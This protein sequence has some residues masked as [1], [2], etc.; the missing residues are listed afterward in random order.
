MDIIY[1]AVSPSGWGA[2]VDYDTKTWTPWNPDKWVL[3]WGGTPVSTAAAAGDPVAEAAQLRS[4]EAYH[5]SPSVP[6]G[7]WLGLA[8]NWAI[9]NSGTLYRVRG[10]NRSGATSGDY[11]DDGIPENHE[12]VAVVFIVGTGQDVSAKAFDTFRNFYAS[13]PQLTLV[14]GHKDAS[15]TGTTCPGPQIYDW[16]QAGGYAQEATMASMWVFG[17]SEGSQGPEVRA[18]QRVLNQLG[19]WLVDGYEKLDV[20]G[21]FG[22]KTSKAVMDVGGW[23]TSNITEF[24]ANSLHQKW[25]AWSVRNEGPAVHDNSAHAPNFARADHSHPEGIWDEARIQA[26]EEDIEDHLQETLKGPHAF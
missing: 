9:G 3:H 11:E 16:I 13:Q 10:N 5:M 15:D 7:P 17:L 23:Q 20:D 2:A 6:G 12:A 22:P 26:I 24:R 14:I 4:W 19:G 8:Y 1:P 18:W 21:V 25:N